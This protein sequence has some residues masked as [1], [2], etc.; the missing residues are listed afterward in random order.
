MPDGNIRRR[1]RRSHR[2]H[3]GGLPAGV[4]EGAPGGCPAGP[5]R[6]PA[7][8]AVGRVS[9]QVHPAGPA[10][11]APADQHDPLPGQNRGGCA[12]DELLRRRC[13]RFAGELFRH[14]R[15]PEMVEP[16]AAFALLDTVLNLPLGRGHRRGAPPADG[17]RRLVAEAWGPAPESRRH[18]SVP[19]SAHGP[20][21][22]RAGG[23][24]PSPPRSRRRTARQHA[25]ALPAGPLGSRLGLDVSPPAGE[26][27]PPGCGE[28]RVPGQPEDRHP[29]GPEGRGRGV[30]AGP[31]GAGGTM[32]TSSTSPPTSPI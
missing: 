22:R 20:G 15:R 14:Y 7:R 2:P 5:G 10:A 26:A 4:S 23:G 12:A 29:L 28:Q 30:P 25:A 3:P 21:P 8:P 13:P 11:D 17:L 18:A 24:R 16:D 19:P 32:P 27:G 9:L 6:G 31:G 1:G